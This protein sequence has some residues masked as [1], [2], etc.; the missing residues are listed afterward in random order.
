[1]IRLAL[2]AALALSVAGCGAPIAVWAPLATAGL[3][4]SAAAFTFDTELAKI[5]DEHHPA[6]ANPPAADLPTPP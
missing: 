4:A 6:P 1:M 5:W 3:G 2:L